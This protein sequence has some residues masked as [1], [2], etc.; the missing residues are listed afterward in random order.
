MSLYGTSIV[1]LL[2]PIAFS[3]YLTFTACLLSLLTMK[4]GEMCT[5]AQFKCPEKEAETTETIRFNTTNF[6]ISVEK[7]ILFSLTFKSLSKTG[8][9]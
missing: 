2:S 4:E 9:P 7:V 1:L 5:R 6:T 3:P 8:R